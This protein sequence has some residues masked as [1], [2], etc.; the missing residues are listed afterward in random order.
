MNWDDVVKMEEGFLGNQLEDRSNC[1][2]MEFSGIIMCLKNNL[3]VMPLDSCCKSQ[4][5]SLFTGSHPSL[6]DNKT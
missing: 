4:Y 6:I 3:P 2:L 5:Q 1:C